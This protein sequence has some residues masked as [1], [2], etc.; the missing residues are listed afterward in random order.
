MSIVKNAFVSISLLAFSAGA[1][2]WGSL[3]NLLIRFYGYQRAGDK[4]F[5]TKN[6]FYKTSPYP[7]SQDNHQG[8]DLSG[9][10]YDAGDFVTGHTRI[11]K[12]GP[13]TILD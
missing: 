5:D 10:W 13:D 3:Q 6:P 9:G 1:Q 8:K 11:L 12:S 7:H 4:A 2:D